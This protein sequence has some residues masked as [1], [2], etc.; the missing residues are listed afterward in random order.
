MV[1]VPSC[2][3]TQRSL[4]RACYGQDEWCCWQLQRTCG[5]ISGRGLATCFVIIHQVYRTAVQQVHHTNRASRLDKRTKSCPVPIQY[6][7]VGPGQGHVGLRF[8]RILS[9]RVCGVFFTVF[10]RFQFHKICCLLLLLSMIHSQASISSEVGS[11]TMPHKVRTGGLSEVVVV[12]CVPVL[13]PPPPFFL[14]V[15]FVDQ[16]DQ[17]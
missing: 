11:S 8:S 13:P 17:L 2:D 1:Q 9:V 12:F 16:S 6:D 5:R 7:I 3:E 15:S 4:R 14:F 10:L